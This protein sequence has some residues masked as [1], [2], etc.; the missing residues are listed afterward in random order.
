M[1]QISEREG[2]HEVGMVSHRRI[3][4]ELTKDDKK[5]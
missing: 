2:V 4:R 1:R 5:P 3:L